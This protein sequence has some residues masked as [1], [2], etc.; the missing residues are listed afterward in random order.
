M[1]INSTVYNPFPTI[2]RQIPADKLAF[3]KEHIDMIRRELFKAGIVIETDEE[4]DSVLKI[5]LDLEII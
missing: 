5:L 4:L 3:N 1:I 2:V